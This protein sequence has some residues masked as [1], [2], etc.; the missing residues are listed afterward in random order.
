[1][2][3]CLALALALAPQ[4]QPP[5]TP[6]FPGLGA[7]ARPKVEI[8]WNRFYDTA[9]LY[10][11]LDRL[12]AL[13]PGL[14]SSQVIGHSSEGRELRVYTLNNPATGADTAK[15]AMWV[16]GN[17]HGNE[18]QG[19]EAV[20][21]VAWYL[22]ENYGAN[23]RVTE[24]VDR[25]A[26]YLLPT[27]NPDGR[28]S[29]F[30]DA[31]NASSSRSGRMPTDDDGD[32]LYDE[33]RPDDLDGDGSIVQMRKH[34]PGEGTH[35]LDPDDPRLLIPVPANERGIKGDWIYVGSEGIDNDGDGRINEDS[36]GGYDMNRAWP[37]A[38]EPEFVQGGAGPYP[39]YWPETR[40]IASFVLAHP[41]IAGVQSFHNSGGMILRGP[42]MEAFGEYPRSDVNVYDEIGREGERM[43]PFYRYMVIWRD[44]YTVFGGFVT[45]TYESLGIVSFTNELWSDDQPFGKA[46]EDGRT[47]DHFF[48]DRLLMGAGFV[49]WH[50]VEHP[51]Y[52]KVEVG[53]F[54]KD[55]GRVPPTFLIEEMVHRNALF[56]IR[57]AEC[58][59]RVVIDEPVVSDL[60][61]G[62]RAI[63]V[64]VRNPALIPTRTA[65]AAQ[66]KSGK[67]D[68]L[69]LSG[70]G[71]EVLASGRR[72][73]RFRPERVELVER[74]PARLVLE[75]GVPGRGELRLRWIVR[76][77]GS[78]KIAWK[79][80]KA[81]AA[82]RTFELR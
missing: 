32:G 17:V 7:T 74:E 6:G 60:G 64:V 59:P 20:A 46:P 67:P 82:E 50:E 56:A 80:E 3:L 18:V 13:W 57:H 5:R 48:D 43:L 1:M 65:R 15:P 19:G 28:D 76:G 12:V 30:H 62:L 8:P 9:A 35:R 22:L 55:V 29:W 21:Y 40:C 79:G 66:V 41:N 11:Q 23:P 10:A 2:K 27:V 26:F 78:V 72:T 25:S 42:G 49:A 68:E 4:D 58:L 54:A 37:S 47:A 69:T 36:A 63:D 31:H 77:S 34:M 52:G 14:L 45:W 75:S 38:W 71:V 39:L 24:L 33:D 16:D 81:L 61:D 51:L 73:D 70:T 44:L 53:G